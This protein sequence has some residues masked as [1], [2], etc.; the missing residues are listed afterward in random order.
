MPPEPYKTTPVFDQTSLPQAIRNAHSTKAGVWGLLRVLEGEVR[1]V[2]HEPRSQVQ[3][4]PQNPAP[5]PPE[6]VHHVEADAPMRM[7][8]EFYREPPV[9]EPAAG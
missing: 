3:V 6:A 2:F 5:I 4:T 7:Q 9:P 1:L 8:V